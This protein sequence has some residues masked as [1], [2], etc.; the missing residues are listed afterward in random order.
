MA[1]MTGKT[2]P[3]IRDAKESGE[4][5]NGHA[6]PSTRDALIEA[7]YHEP[8]KAEIV[9][10]RIKRFEMTGDEPSRAAT[11]IV[12]ALMTWVRSTRAT[13]RAYSD[14]VAFL[15]TLPDRNSFAPDASYYTGPPAGMKFLPEPPVFA[16]EVRSEGDYGPAAERDMQ[17]KREDYFATTTEVVWDVDLL[18]SEAIIR[19]FTKSGGAQT[20][21]AVYNRGEIA[22]AEPAVPGFT[23]AVDD[24]FE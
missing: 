9:A 16:V 18:G 14:G 21:V 15:A 1:T 7:L 24:L 2:A 19:K 4:S 5:R 3:V 10:G 22:D 12:F 17:A 23:F 6:I 11:N 20:P 13:G 8:G